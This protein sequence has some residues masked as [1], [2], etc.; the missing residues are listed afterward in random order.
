MKKSIALLVVLLLCSLTAQAAEPDAEELS[1]W[2][3]IRNKIEKITPKQKPTVTTAVGG[4]R[5]SQDDAQELYWKGEEEASLFSAEEIELFSAAL[6]LAEE[7]D[8]AGATAGFREFLG[9]FPE[10]LLADDAQS[11]LQELG[12]AEEAAPA[13]PADDFSLPDLPGFKV[14]M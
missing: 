12:K 2:E 9:R 8:S 13:A 14:G 7:G 11:A 1:L 10:S 4:V 6:Q 3:K 5:G